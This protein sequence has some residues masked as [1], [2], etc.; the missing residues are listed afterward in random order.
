[1]SNMYSATFFR[2][3]WILTALDAG[4]WT[5]MKIRTKWLRDVASIVFS[6]FYLFAAEQADEKA[7]KVHGM[8]TVEHVRVS[9]NKGSSPYLS[10]LQN[11]LRPRF[12]KWPPREIRIWRPQS[13]DY[14]EPVLAWLYFDGNM[15]E[16]K[17]CNKVIL[18]IP[19]GGFVAM[20]PRTNEDRLLCW[21]AKTRIPVVSLDYRKAPEYPYPYALN[22]CYDAYSSIV[23]SKGRCIG[24]NGNVTPH[25]ILV[26]DSAGGNLAA[27]TT[28][29]IIES[30]NTPAKRMRGQRKLPVPTG[31]I[32]VY[33]AM[34]MNIGN[35][36]SDE[37]MALIQDKR[38]R[39]TNRSIVRRKSAQYKDL[40][41]T[42]RLV[43]D[44]DE[45]PVSKSLGSSKDLT[46]STSVTRPELDCS[47]NV[48]H[49]EFSH[50]LREAWNQTPKPP[51]SGTSH[52]SA[53]LKTRLAVSSMM[54]YF[55]DRVLS[56][57]LLRAVIILYIGPHNRPDFA[58]D[59]FLCPVL[60]P[61]SLLAEFPKTIFLTGE[62]DP[63]VDDTVIFAGRLKRARREAHQRKMSARRAE[64]GI[65]AHV[66]NSD[67]EEEDKFDAK[68]FVEVVLLPGVSHGFLQFPS[69]FP[70]AWKLLDK[71][72][73]WMVDIF[74]DEES[75]ERDFVRLAA[76]SQLRE[77]KK[78]EEHVEGAKRE[79]GDEE[80][81]RIC[82][83]EST[84]DE[85][86]LEIG[87]TK[88]RK[89]AS[90]AGAGASEPMTTTSGLSQRGDGAVQGQEGIAGEMNG[91]AVVEEY[92]GYQN[93]ARNRRKSRVEH[94]A[95]D[96][97]RLE[98]S[99]DLLARRM[100][101]IT[102]GLTRLTQED[103]D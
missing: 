21:A 4:F 101:G 88:L 76:Q 34:D 45:S 53:P 13:S 72:A 92:S 67:E 82:A 28:L 41:G 69:L 30:G 63:L 65:Y 36:M 83:A 46:R 96:L 25:V 48:P 64:K 66:P 89:K 60:A 12:M 42:P 20:S 38:D 1:M 15:E 24:L 44:R 74:R 100:H 84:D 52:H 71:C 90:G 11:L 68:D 33:P 102:S 31:L 58:T 54:S 40:V 35:W 80:A 56:P 103:P 8:L 98:S 61:D 10:F 87:M 85:R 91:G 75:K 37:Q 51:R 6:L 79:N 47:S 43:D 39:G 55:N 94:T 17:T 78:R 81:V 50:A 95:Q 62:R 59:Y 2:A 19:G 77:R 3:T 9:W 18:D 27:A 93:E 7:R 14:D 32:L 5:A 97:T 99:E 29:M 57:E 16:L 49:P 70:P 22:E 26:G 86:P 23:L 73:K